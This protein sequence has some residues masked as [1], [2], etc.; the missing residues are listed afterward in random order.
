MFNPVQ[1]LLS[2]LIDPKAITALMMAAYAV[3]AIA[4]FS[5]LYE[6]AP[7]MLMWSNNY[8]TAWALLLI[9]GGLL[10]LCAAPR[11]IWFAER[12]AIIMCGTG[13]LA[14]IISE[15]Y[16][17]FHSV[18]GNQVLVDTDGN[19]V[20]NITITLTGLVSADQIGA[21]DFLFN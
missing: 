15:L 17:H 12:P 3:A 2:R 7:K 5:V 21:D 9:F 6:G 16:L 1:F 8:E 11:G 13:L 19:G 14:Y 4:G 20:V 10:G 18:Q